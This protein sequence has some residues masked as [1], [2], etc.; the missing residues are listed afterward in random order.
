MER[1]VER[2]GG[3]DVHKDT[4]VATVRVPGEGGRRHEETHS[5]GTTLPSLLT[6]LDWLVSH[7]VT[8]VAMEAT[9]VDWKPVYYVLEDAIECWLLNARHLKAVPGRKTD[10]ADSQWIAQLVEHGLV[11]PSFVPPKPIRDLRDLTRY[12]KAQIQERSREA[13]QLDKVLQDAGLKLSSVASDILGKSGR[14]ML[15][16]LV[17][18]DAETP[19]RISS[20][21]W[22]VRCRPRLLPRCQPVAI[23]GI[24]DVGPLRAD[25]DVQGIGGIV[26]IV[27]GRN[28]SAQRIERSALYL[29]DSVRGV[30][31]FSGP[32]EGT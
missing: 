2:V 16:A 21:C 28:D 13:Q 32:V 9:G 29:G 12:R 22:W 6:L 14:A 24:A 7:Q 30:F 15:E 20:P 31:D 5:F 26:G 4:V 3:L 11:R 19:A 18:E 10:V 23:K 25:G 17:A 8:L 1:I 27:D